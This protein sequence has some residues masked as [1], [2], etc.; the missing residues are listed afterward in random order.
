MPLSLTFSSPDTLPGRTYYSDDALGTWRKP[1]G[2]YLPPGVDLDKGF[3]DVVIYLHGF[4]VGSIQDLFNNDRVKP[5]EQVLASGKNVVLVAPYLGD[6][7][8]PDGGTYSTKDLT[9]NWGELY[10][11]DVLNALVPPKLPEPDLMHP[12][13]GFIPQLRV[14]KLVIAC[15]SAGGSAMRKLVNT[16]GRYKHNLVECW[17][18][19]CLYG[20]DRKPDDA[21]FWYDWATSKDGRELWIS[22]G[23]S[24]VYESVKLYLMKKGL[25]TSEGARRNPDGAEVTSI[26]V[27]IGIFAAKPIE[28]VMDLPKLLEA[29][30]PK[31]GAPQSHD[32]S[33]V[34]KAAEN[35]ASKA[36]WPPPKQHGAMHYRIA[37]EGL[38]D[39]LESSN[40]L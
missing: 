14:N 39:R 9:G 5:R 28:D 20:V 26:D 40:N 7:E 2:V 15:H 29:T 27:T 17:G 23:I 33:F 32:G 8:Q 37:R 6:G 10:I 21:S 36:G 4:Y 11:N 34:W 24:T 35:V 30:K 16:L 1:T 38:L 25:A 3:V 12:Q 13:V 22:Y 19:D 31:P 18:F